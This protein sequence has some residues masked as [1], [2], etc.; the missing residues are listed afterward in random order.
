M[1]NS[2]KSL[3]LIA[4]L[5]VS[6]SGCV[7]ITLAPA[8]PYD[9]G[10]GTT[11][12]LNR[13]WNDVSALWTERPKKVRLLSRDGPLLN[14]LYLTD[15]LVDGD[16]FAP[17]PRRESRTPV[18]A[19]SMSITE[20]VEFVAQSLGSFGFERVETSNLR[21]VEVSGTRAA[22]FDISAM[23]GEGL[24]VSG[25]GQVIK[26]G[27]ELFVAVYI[28]PTEHYFEASR[29]SAEHAMSSLSF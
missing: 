27:E 24:K 26:N 18:Y 2:V 1:R 15:G 16:V 20:Q 8:G 17:S 19:T 7:S 11:V 28:A 23:T 13:P 22:R 12:E 21:P 14:R 4:A 3:A 29:E 9:V 5:S 10:G 25:I 6:L